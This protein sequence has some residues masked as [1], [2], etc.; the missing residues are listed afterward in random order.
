MAPIKIEFDVSDT[1]KKVMESFNGLS[2]EESI[3]RLT[4]FTQFYSQE[5]LRKSILEGHQTSSLKSMFGVNILNK[6]GQIVANLPPLNWKNP[7][8]NVEVFEMHMHHTMLEY[9]NI[10][11]STCLTWCLNRIREEFKFNKRDLEFLIKDNPIIPEGR[12]E[13]FKSAIYMGLKGEVYEAIHILAPQVENLFR[14]IAKTA[15]GLTVT[16]ENDGSS[17][18]KVLSSIFNL[19][20][21]KDCYDNDILF[22]FKGML[23]EQ[24]GAN[25]RNNIAHGLMDAGEGN[26]GSSIYF[27]CATMKLLSY[28]S[29]EALLLL[30]NSEKLKDCSWNKE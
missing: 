29:I 7:E 30:K 1:Y 8:E 2:F 21:L 26:S 20:E 13:V 23:N 3:I 28:T 16:L 4:Q 5:E 14:N 19:P 17:K 18:E 15:G 22:V 25:I 6:N 12:E 24:T 9:A 10:E 27:V 11:G